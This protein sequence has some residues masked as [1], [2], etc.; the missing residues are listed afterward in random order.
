MIVIH[1]DSWTNNILQK[2]D[3]IIFRSLEMANGSI[4]MRKFYANSIVALDRAL[5]AKFGV[6]FYYHL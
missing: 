3:F 1:I 6:F 4:N 2:F 5:V